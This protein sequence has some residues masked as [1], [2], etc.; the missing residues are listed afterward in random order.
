MESHLGSQLG[1]DGLTRRQDGGRRGE[2]VPAVE[3][4]APRWEGHLG[5]LDREGSGRAPEKGHRRREEPVVGTYQVSPLRLDNDGPPAGTDPG[6]D[7]GQDHPGRH[8]LD[9]PE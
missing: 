8:V 5:V 2:A 9:G 1:R 7:N 6:V 4:P 3:G